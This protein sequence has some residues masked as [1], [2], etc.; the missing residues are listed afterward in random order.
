VL[1]FSA[2]KENPVK[3]W[4]T[5]LKAV[6]F[7]SWKIINFIKSIVLTKY[8]QVQDTLIKMVWLY[9]S[10]F[11]AQSILRKSVSRIYHVAYG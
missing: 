5:T 2:E 9:A 1:T 7:V 3:F 11:S 10:S 6:L 8:A 4:F